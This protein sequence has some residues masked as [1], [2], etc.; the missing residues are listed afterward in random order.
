MAFVAGG[1]GGRQIVAVDGAEYSGYGPEWIVSWPL[2]FSETGGAI[3]CRLTSRA[4]GKNCIGRD[5]RREE[6]FERV[7]P[8]VLSRDGKR[9]AY[10]AHEGDRCF[11]VVD[12]ER[13]PSSEFMSD[14]AIS[15]DGKVVAY[16]EKRQGRWTLVVGA[17]RTPIDQQPSTVFVSPDGRSAG[18]VHD[19]GGSKV[20]VV[21]DGKPGDAFSLTGLPVF[22]RDG[23]TVA[24][25][26]DEG[27][28][29]YIVIG[30]AKVEVSGR[31]SD[32]VFSTDGRRVGYGARIGR[33]I[34]WK[35]L[36]V[37]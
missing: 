33:E 32:P 18:Y 19:A 23:K 1:E 27:Q 28:R 17:R 11:V 16:G 13:G 24:Y 26:A 15:A 9:I 2:C 25:A 29:Q 4:S 12:G 34:W 14:P 20:R 30:D 8:P 37:P 5:G 6:E 31:V 35:V 22:S 36:D 7:G 21:V 3:A 10:R